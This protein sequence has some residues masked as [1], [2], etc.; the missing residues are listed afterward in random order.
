MCINNK[1]MISSAAAASPVTRG[2]GRGVF[3]RVVFRPITNRVTRIYGFIK[4]VSLEVSHHSNVSVYIYKKLKF[5]H[6]LLT[7]IRRVSFGYF[8]CLF[9]CAAVILYARLNFG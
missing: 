6:S 4:S 2:S 9:S 1:K 3:D 7:K 8:V 5:N